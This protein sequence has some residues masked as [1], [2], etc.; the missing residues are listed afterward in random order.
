M[1]RSLYE[2][3][4]VPRDAADVA[5]VRSAF[6]RQVLKVHPD[7]LP[8]TATAA[9][10][11]AACAAFQEVQRA[12]RTLSDPVMRARYD[13]AELGR[14]VDTVGRISDVFVWSEFD[15]K[16][17]DGSATMECRCGGTY[18]VFGDGPAEGHPVHAECDSCSL[19]VEVKLG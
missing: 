13:A 19:M 1:G 6:K 5:A 15:G 10:R 17:D 2:V 18:A 8:P 7:K 16:G 3:L 12:V 14:V 4:G 11:A 9:E